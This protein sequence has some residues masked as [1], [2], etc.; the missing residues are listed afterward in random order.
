MLV[1]TRRRGESIV[2]RDDI[3]ATVIEVRGD[4]VRLGIEAPRE[5]FTM[6]STDRSVLSNRKS[7][8]S[9]LERQVY[10]VFSETAWQA[11]SCCR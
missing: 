10:R 7:S 9:Y 8:S 2:I 6:R 5:G 1:L 11:L 3:L 4:R